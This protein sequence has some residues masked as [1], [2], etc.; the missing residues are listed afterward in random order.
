M[1]S[2]KPI[3]GSA[4]AVQQNREGSLHGASDVYNAAQLASRLEGRLGD[5]GAVEKT[6]ESAEA[7][8]ARLAGM[9]QNLGEITI[10]GEVEDPRK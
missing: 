8:E 5:G 9:A 2:E 10:P 3:H 1:E 6:P 7:Q 4:E